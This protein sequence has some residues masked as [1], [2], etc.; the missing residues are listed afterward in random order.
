MLFKMV[1]IAGALDALVLC[2]ASYL[3]VCKILVLD[4]ADTGSKMVSLID[5]S[6]PLII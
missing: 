5:Y 6:M 3:A 4:I 1:R 2:L